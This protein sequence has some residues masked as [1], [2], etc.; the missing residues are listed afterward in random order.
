[1]R[2]LIARKYPLTAGGAM[3]SSNPSVNMPFVV[4]Q[5]ILPTPTA[6]IMLTPLKTLLMRQCPSRCA[7]QLSSPSI[8]VGLCR[9]LS[10]RLFGGFRRLPASADA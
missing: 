2:A 8:G 10:T 6:R 7:F 9:Y 3:S 4:S 5:K 1:M